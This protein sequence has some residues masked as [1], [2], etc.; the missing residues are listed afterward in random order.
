MF[1]F[2]SITGSSVWQVLTEHSQGERQP[3]F[4]G[5]NVFMEHM[6]S[7]CSGCFLLLSQNEKGVLLLSWDMLFETESN[8]TLTAGGVSDVTGSS[9]VSLLLLITY[10]LTTLSIYSELLSP[11]ECHLLP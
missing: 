3:A 8:L 1:R 4:A 7:V 2:P 11:A 10:N 6:I 5:N 9:D